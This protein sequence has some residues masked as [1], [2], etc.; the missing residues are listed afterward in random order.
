MKKINYNTV[1][2][3]LVLA[4]GLGVIVYFASKGKMTE[5]LT[6]IATEAPMLAE[7]MPMGIPTMEE[8]TA[9]SD[10][11]LS[12]DELLPKLSQEASDFAKENPVSKMLQEQ[13]FLVSGYHV[14]VNTVLQSNKIPYH[15][16]RSSPAIGKNMVS[17][18]LNSSIEAPAGSSTR[19]L[20]EIGTA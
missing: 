7:E 13:N 18:W 8:P 6:D 5:K 9:E 20:F 2:W 19:R 12:T 11:V 4:L 14:G 15:D 1:F 10:K 16:L 3:A 17:P